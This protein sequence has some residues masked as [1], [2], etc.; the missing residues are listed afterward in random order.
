[1]FGG[2]V[3]TSDNSIIQGQPTLSCGV[4]SHFGTGKFVVSGDRLESVGGEGR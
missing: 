3:R 2:G 1:M 4:G